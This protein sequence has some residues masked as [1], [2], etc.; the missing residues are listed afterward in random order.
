MSD[1]PLRSCDVCGQID[2]HPRHIIATMGADHDGYVVNEDA[3]EA[4]FNAKDLDPRDVVRIVTDLRDLSLI[5]RHMDCCRDAGCPDGSCD[6]V[7]KDVKDAHGLDIV[8]K[9][10]PKVEV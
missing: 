8:R 7:L 10:N 6:A 1:R 3:V 4:A 9:L 2:D 5:E